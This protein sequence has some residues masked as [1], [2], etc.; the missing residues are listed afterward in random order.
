[1]EDGQGVGTN[2]GHVEVGQG[3]G[4]DVGHVEVVEGDREQFSKEFL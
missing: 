4:T 1:M 3:G 2:V